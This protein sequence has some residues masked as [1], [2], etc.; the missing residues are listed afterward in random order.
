MSN[1]QVL[2]LPQS[3]YVGA[4]CIAL[5][6]KAWSMKSSPPHRIALTSSPFIRWARSLCS[7]TAMWRSANHVPLSIM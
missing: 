2:G 3:N 1:V 7:D 4:V 6:E 5:A